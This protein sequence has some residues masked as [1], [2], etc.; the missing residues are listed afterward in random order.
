MNE[1]IPGTASTGGAVT[2]GHTPGPWRRDVR[3]G[4]AAIAGSATEWIAILPYTDT[5]SFGLTDL[6][7]VNANARLIAAAPDMIAA[8]C[9][10]EEFLGDQSDCEID[11][12]GGYH[13]NRAMQLLCEVRE[14]IAKAGGQA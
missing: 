10:V 5:D 9:E 11:S 8:L 7:E 4:S 6:A 13:P 1:I 14:A 12:E 3:K 2:S